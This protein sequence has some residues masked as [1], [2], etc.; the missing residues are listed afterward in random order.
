MSGFLHLG[1]SPLGAKACVA[2]SSLLVASML[3]SVASTGCLVTE[4]P[5]FEAPSRT[6][7]RLVN[8]T[9]APAELI[10]A[11]VSGQVYELP[12]FQ[13]QIVSEDAGQR[14]DSRLVVDYGVDPSNTG[15]VDF[16]L[17]ET[18]A[19]GKMSDGPRPKDKKAIIDLKLPR[20]QYSPD[21][22]GGRSCRTVTLLVSHE[23]RSNGARYCPTRMEDSD[24]ASWFVVLCP[25]ADVSA[26]ACPVVDCPT[27]SQGATSYCID[28]PQ[29]VGP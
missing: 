12:S 23:F 13:F 6:A 2:R 3:T 17:G 5:S 16:D 25:G 28:E 15:F 4:S 20:L 18:I 11:P 21:N 19:P 7:P 27:A 1:R 29:E 24:Q 26:E 8:L 14:V 9:P 10:R 22:N